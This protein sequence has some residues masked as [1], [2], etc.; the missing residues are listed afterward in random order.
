MTTKIT[1]AH[2]DKIDLL[3]IYYFIP[4]QVRWID[5]ISLEEESKKQK[6]QKYFKRMFS[7]SKLWK[8]VALPEGVDMIYGINNS[9]YESSFANILPG[10]SFVYSFE[11]YLPKWLFSP[12][13]T[14]KFD[15]R[16]KYKYKNEVHYSSFS[17]NFLVRPPIGANIIG[18]IIGGVLGTSA[19][20]LQGTVTS[21]DMGFDITFMTATLLS[22]ILGIVMVVFSSRRTGEV[23]PILTIEDFW[24]GMLAGFLV[25]YL[26]HEFFGKVV[27]LGK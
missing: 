14:V 10:E 20:W 6:E 9:N 19:K 1:N 21:K 16:V 24:G 5:E 25:G 27:P 13:F 18:A 17:L 3:Q 15:G 8:R 2:D 26:G 11:A 22:I 4:H 7:S 12:G 23:Q